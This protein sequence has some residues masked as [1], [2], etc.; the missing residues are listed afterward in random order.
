MRKKTASVVALAVAACFAGRSYG[1]DGADAQ[2]DKDKTKAAH[3][4]ILPAAL[5][6]VGV[7]AI[8][9]LAGRHGG[10]SGGNSNTS[11]TGGGSPTS[12]PN[13]APASAPRTLT[14]TSP[15]D[16][17]TPE[18]NA[19]A[20]LRW[21]KASSMY[22]NGHYAWYSG[23]APDAA[24]G[25]GIGVKI[26][27]A[28]TGINPREAA[29]GSSIAI[30]TASSY[31]Y[32]NNR[33]GAALDDYG[34]GTHV[35]GILAAPK[36]GSGMHGLA[37]NATLIDFK[38]GNSNGAITA[39]DAQ[40]GDMITRAG[41]AGAMIINN[42]W[43]LAGSD[44]TAFTAQDLQSAQP[45]MIAASRA[46][47]AKGGVVVF[48]AGN[49]A[50]ANPSMQAG[51]PY[52]ISGIEPGWLAVVAIDETGKLASYSNRC[53]VAAA[54]CLAAPGGSAN[55]GIYSMYNNGG[56]AYLYGTSMAAPHASAAI[57]ALKSMFVNLSYLQ[58]RDRLL[59]TANHGGAYA[60]ASS[61]GQ[62]LIDLDAAS[63]PVGGISVP[64]GSSANGAT[65][66]VA[67]TAV[68]LQPG[69][70]RAL[71]LQPWVLVVDNYQRAP[72]WIP[73]STLFH[74]ATPVLLERQ[75]ASL[76][77][78][79]LATRAQSLGPGLRLGY[80]PGLHSAVAA[81]FG[82]YRIGFSQ[83]AGGE[84]VLGSQLEFASLP[85][86][87]APGV[88][89]VALGYSADVGALRLG[90]IG[91]LPTAGTTE[92]RTL[93]SSSLGGRNGFGAVA[94]LSD[95]STTY[96]LTLATADHFERPLGIVTSGA[97]AV[98]QSAAFSGG[99][100]VRRE[101]GA[102]TVLDASLEMAR[103]R[104]QADL[105]LSAPAFDMRSA[106]FGA[107]TA[108]GAKTIVSATLK[109]DWTSGGA[110]QLSVPLTIAENGDIGRVSYALP[111]DELVGRTA[112][113]LRLDHQINRSVALRASVTR[114][115]YGFGT[116]LNG[117][118]A[119]VEIAR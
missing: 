111:Y 96:G 79:P 10:D 71:R 51:M 113:T 107:R 61:Y 80:A 28:D 102:S 63:S 83:G 84:S 33:P 3:A 18:Y 12:G 115:R 35:A 73:A 54:W 22:Y 86:L 74:E 101:L 100:F 52:R 49:D 40:V 7:A 17:E 20:G 46:Y 119:V 90:F 117:I 85:H 34:H 30:D 23:N 67:G 48:A 95:G 53:G 118:A 58:I 25:T 27:L 29:T 39:T 57:A 98:A 92:A 5:A 62:G 65:A 2:A 4:L 50:A 106:N 14:Y 21:V 16:F 43:A 64:T 87:A 94:Q 112:V 70:V 44:I 45:N 60:D 110:A 66:A 15:A 97:F 93:D 116:T 78:G 26:A 42:S 104:P 32:I 13:G 55:S 31:D 81:N 38:V 24:A 89:S 9:A 99:A 36:N 47:V 82:T 75:W 105:A 8:A 68:Q 91:T 19:Q 59:Y 109:R 76:A 37:Y 88:E 41:N 56:Y 72:F 77:S 114:E 103:H 1:G 108:L 69:S 11:G 6:V